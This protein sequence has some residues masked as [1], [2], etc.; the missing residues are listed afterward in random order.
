[1]AQWISAE[2]ANWKCLRLKGSV[3]PKGRKPVRA[4]GLPFGAVVPQKR[5]VARKA[6][7][8]LCQKPVWVHRKNADLCYDLVDTYALDDQFAFEGDLPDESPLAPA[9][10]FE[11]PLRSDEESELKDPPETKAHGSIGQA[12]SR[13]SSTEL[14]PL[15]RPS[16]SADWEPPTQYGYSLVQS[17]PIEDP[18]AAIRMRAEARPL[19]T[20][21]D[22]ANEEPEVLHSCTEDVYVGSEYYLCE[23]PENHEGPHN[24]TEKLFQWGDPGEFEDE[25]ETENLGELALAAMILLTEQASH[26]LMTL[27]SDPD[28]NL[29]E[30]DAALRKKLE[31]VRASVER[32]I[33]WCGRNDDDDW[34]RG[35]VDEAEW[36][37]RV[38]DR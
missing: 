34:S 19:E 6:L 4:N 17:H 28:L 5:K 21:D 35:K 13:G 2:E 12:L 24:D 25:G 15:I 1:M 22:P 32:T 10:T 29:V 14:P 23:L 11:T 38:L 31:R 26:P 36:V 3:T 27:C 33:E 8:S 18:D 9:A 16:T 20:L 37:I 30:E 7:E